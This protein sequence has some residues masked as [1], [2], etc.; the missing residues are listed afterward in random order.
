MQK[1]LHKFERCPSPY[2]RLHTIVR[3][4]SLQQDFAALVSGNSSS[5]VRVKFAV[6]RLASSNAAAQILFVEPLA[7]SPHGDFIL[8][9]L[10]SSDAR[11]FSDISLLIILEEPLVECR[12][13]AQQFNFQLSRS[14]RHGK[15]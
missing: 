2:A 3:C 15:V 9:Q 1:F 13:T 6:P 14:E 7:S 11:G 10:P 5:L 12:C 8:P 4:F